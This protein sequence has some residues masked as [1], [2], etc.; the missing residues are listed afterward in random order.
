[1]PRGILTARNNQN[2]NLNPL[3]VIF[4]VQNGIII[5]IICCC[6]I[7]ILSQGNKLQCL[8]CNDRSSDPKEWGWAMPAFFGV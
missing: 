3:M 6:H 8:R 7:L 1:M 5:L 2:N 4:S